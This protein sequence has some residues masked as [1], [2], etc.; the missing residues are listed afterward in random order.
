MAE[1]VELTNTAHA[2]LKV[3]PEATMAIAAKQHV[4]NLRAAEVGKAACDCP[5]FFS[6]NTANGRWALSAMTSLEPEHNLFVREGEWQAIY[7]PT[8][9]QTFPLFL[10][11]ADNEKGY[12]VGLDE[13]SSAFSRE[14][15][16]PLFDDQGQPSIYLNHV[17]TLLEADIEND[18]QT[19][20]F[21]Q[22]LDELGL[23][24]PVDL[25]VQAKEGQGRNLTGLFT[26]DEDRFNALE[27]KE[28]SELHQRGY[29]GVII[30]MMV[31]LFQLNRL[32]RRNNQDSSL[33]AIAQV[34]LQVA[35]NNDAAADASLVR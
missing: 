5:V 13:S 32:V 24:K 14:S 9:M 12:A 6:R 35:R 28:A 25:L 21:T 23:I 4:M 31:S 33:P 7:Q 16:E 22:R 17:R 2:D 3:S 26:L 18:V 8:V 1:L 27:E 34:K 30:A 10:V 11:N 29:L 15:G 19:M 20:H